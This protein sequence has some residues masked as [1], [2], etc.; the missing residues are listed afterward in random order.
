MTRRVLERCLTSL[1]VVLG[2]ITLIFL[3]LNALP[4]DPASLVAG[5]SASAETIAHVRAQ[6]GT[7]RPLT[8]QYSSY[9][10]GLLHADLGH[11][12]VTHEPVLQRLLAQFPA[13][14][15]LTA[16]ASVVAVALGV[17]LGVL[18]A[19]QRGR[20]LDRAIQFI[21]LGLGSMPAF[22]LG[23]LAILIF[24]VKLGWLPV[25]GDGGVLPSIL[26]VLC[27]GVVVSVP[28]LRLSRAATL[29][30]LHQ[31][32][33]VTLR[34]KGLPARRIFYVHVLRN[35]LIACLTLLSVLIGELLSGA[36]IIETLFARQGIGRLTVE[37]ITQKDLPMVQGAILFASIGYVMINLLVDVCYVLIDPRLRVRMAGGMQ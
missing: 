1:G 3:I 33:V 37:A 22:W 34:A 12:Y 31:P 16:A 35:A 20:F 36:V 7:A 26:P 30:E 6:L 10:L 13:T 19:W 23:S 18:S 2:A 15:Q 17:G 11:S 5:E 28:L 4:G 8:E 29:E 27:L 24:S 9:L 25:I 21:A 14:L 32:Y